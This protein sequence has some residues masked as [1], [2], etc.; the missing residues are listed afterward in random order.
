M[1]AKSKA[2]TTFTCGM[3]I[4]VFVA[5]CLLCAMIYGIS[6]YL[7]HAELDSNIAKWHIKGS[8]TYKITV[9]VNSVA[10]NT[11]YVRDGRV[12][13]ETNPLPYD[14][15]VKAPIEALFDRLSSL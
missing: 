5:L 4:W 9:V 15:F 3:L 7:G 8:S 10:L 2:Q 13:L 6:N 11:V 14:P 12:V 1:Q